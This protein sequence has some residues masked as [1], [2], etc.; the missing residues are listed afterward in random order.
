MMTL[1]PYQYYSDRFVNF[2]WRHDFDWKLY[3]LESKKSTLSSLPRL[4]IQY[5]I[6]SGSL[7]HPE[8]HQGVN[9]IATGE[10]Y[11]ELG[12]LLKSLLR[13]RYAG[14]YYLT[15]DYGAFYH[16]ADYSDPLNHIR[17]V[18]GAGVDL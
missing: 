4:C 16:L 8:V 1:S 18:F 17:M 3:R 15:L 10:A 14:L 5:G 6:L 12:L 7:S 13:V 11:Q 2:I 9:L